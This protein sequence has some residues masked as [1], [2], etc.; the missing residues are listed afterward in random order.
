MDACRYGSQRRT[1]AGL[2]GAAH[3]RTGPGPGQGCARCCRC[4]CEAVKE[5]ERKYRASRGLVLP[6]LT[7]RLP[8]V[9]SI[10]PTV[11]ERMTATYY[12]TADLRLAREGITLRHRSGGSDDGW[13][14]KLPLAKTDSM[15]R[16]EI[17]LPGDDDIPDRLR[18][19][20]T[21]YVRFADLQ[22]A[23]T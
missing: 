5:V 12:D 10:D 15:V 9:A 7:G 13:H 6:D 3:H 22:P 4:E 19:A 8:S 18:R 17:Q 14:L 21:A 2:P 23:A 20:V 11:I 1:V 16:D